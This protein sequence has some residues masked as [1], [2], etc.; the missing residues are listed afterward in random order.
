MMKQMSTYMFPVSYVRFNL[1]NYLHIPIPTSQEVSRLSSDRNDAY[2]LMHAS[3]TTEMSLKS[4][5]YVGIISL[6]PKTS[7][8]FPKVTLTFQLVVKGLKNCGFHIR[9]YQV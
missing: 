7:T 4:I 3:V 8:R 2:P 1:L 5:L 6:K 9:L